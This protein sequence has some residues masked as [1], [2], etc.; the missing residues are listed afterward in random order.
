MKSTTKKSR[1]EVLYKDKLSMKISTDYENGMRNTYENQSEMVAMT[2]STNH[3]ARPGAMPVQQ[4]RKDY[5]VQ[6]LGG[7]QELK[8][9][10]RTG[11]RGGGKV[12]SLIGK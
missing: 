2:D 1:N 8:V 9:Y 6:E 12:G 11:A 4:S 5:K 3:T 10:L 7:Y